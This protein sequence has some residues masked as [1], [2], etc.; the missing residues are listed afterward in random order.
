MSVTDIMK[1][2]YHYQKPFEL[3]CG[4]V[5]E[6][7][8]ICYYTYGK[9]SA[10]ADNVIWICHALTA[11]AD[12]SG[13]WSGLVGAGKTFD[14]DQYF[15]VC[16]N[17]LGS[18]Y[19]TTG[20]TSKIP[21]SEEIYGLAFPRFTV[22]DMVAVHSL[23]RQHLK[24]EQ[25]H[26]LAG[27]SMGGYQVL[28][29]ALMEP[30]HIRNLF[31]I[32]TSVEESAWGKA[33]HTAQRM[34]IAADP[35]WMEGQQG[36]GDKGL[37]AARAIGMLSYRNYQLFKEQQSD[38]QVD[39]ST[40]PKAG[41]YLH[42]QAQKLADRFDPLTYYRLTEAMDTHS[43]ARGRA[44]TAAEILKEI[45]QPS[46]VMGI[47]SDILCPVPEQEFLAR[48][49]P[50]ATFHKIDSGY[51]HDGFLIEDNKIAKHLTEWMQK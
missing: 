42:H 17:I 27:G 38:E 25:I 41:S 10:Q 39:L 6:G 8:E 23:L 22:R 48:H 5:L 45:Q 36:I 35:Q 3:E 44:G 20:P 47:S 24:I 4:A 12:V 9:L 50:Y 43:I 49:L 31:L 2:L 40:Q 29:W 18:C 46:L 14:P 37:K 13:W 1:H 15:I 26:I 7:I 28:E 34:A 16:A 30:G 19:G 51:G 11:D 21:G 32:A 33:I